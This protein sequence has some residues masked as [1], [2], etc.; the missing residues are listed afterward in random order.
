MY[1]MM[2]DVSGEER[3]F[4]FRG[5]GCRTKMIEWWD[6]HLNRAGGDEDIRRIRVWGTV[7][8]KTEIV[9]EWTPERASTSWAGL[10]AAT[11]G[12]D[13]KMPGHRRHGWVFGD[14]GVACGRDISSDSRTGRGP[15]KSSGSKDQNAALMPVLMSAAQ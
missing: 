14:A 3:V 4:L 9:R 7:G 10:T 11:R 5:P 15:R 6:D 8:N 1:K 13:L 2:I 12:V